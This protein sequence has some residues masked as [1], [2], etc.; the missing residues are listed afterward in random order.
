[1]GPGLANALPSRPKFKWDAKSPPWTDGKGNQEQFKLAVEDW[2]EYHD[3]LPAGNSHKLAV[4]M[5]GIVLKSQLFGQAA[6]LCAGIT[7][8]QLRSDYG[9]TMVVNAVY[10]RDALSVV[11]E[12]YEGFNALL[13]TRRA[14]SE[15]LKAFELRFS[16][17]VTKFNSLSETTKLP[18][19]ITALMLLSHANIEQSARV[20]VLAAAAPSTA[21]FDDNSTNDD[22]LEAVTY[23]QLA[24]VVK[25][26]ERPSGSTAP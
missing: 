18:Q 13:T 2:Q 5:Q 26:C 4:P 10:Q 17:A 23:K 9:V 6:D 14:G 8:E 16:A 19:C 12:A 7:R 20:S 1:M 21:D 22:F 11:S 25:Q 24:S 15:S 3:S